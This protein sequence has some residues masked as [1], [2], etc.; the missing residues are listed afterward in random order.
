MYGICLRRLCP[1][2]LLRCENTCRNER[3]FGIIDV[4]QTCS[5]SWR[6]LLKLRD[7]AKKISPFQCRGWYGH[8]SFA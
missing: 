5:W 3:V 1:Y 4:S 7:I 6:K 8:P 2:G